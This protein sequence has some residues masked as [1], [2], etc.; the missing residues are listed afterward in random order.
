MRPTNERRGGRRTGAQMLKGKRVEDHFPSL[1]GLLF[2]PCAV[3]LHS[4][5]RK[6]RWRL[7]LGAPEG[8]WLPAPLV[9]GGD[10]RG[11]RTQE[12]IDRW[13]GG[14]QLHELRSAG[15]E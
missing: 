12:G 15:M 7:R 6:D 10:P 11:E 2:S 1:R 3:Y 14:S 4:S 5:A 13:T 8:L 9:L